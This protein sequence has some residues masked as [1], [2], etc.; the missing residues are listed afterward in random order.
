MTIVEK[1][2]ENAKNKNIQ[3]TSGFSK[4]QPTGFDS[5]SI[6]Q[7][8]D[9]VIMPTTMPTVYKQKFGEDAEGND[10]FAEF[11]VVDVEHEGK[12]TRAINLFPS[13]FTKN[14]WPS[15]KNADGEIELV[16]GGPL[17]PKGT[18]VDL[19][20][21]VQGTVGSNGETDMQLGVEKLLGKKIKVSGQEQIDVQVFR[22]G[23][24]VNSL[25]K[26]NL[27]TYDIVQ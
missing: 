19:Y 25:K 22:N 9:V 5:D 7:K 18:A 13:S 14:I 15:K 26:T 21:S 20:K 16:E 23:K 17:N 1:A 10:I 8:D 3:P 4:S 24:R 6:L 11:I 2:A 27:F 12:P